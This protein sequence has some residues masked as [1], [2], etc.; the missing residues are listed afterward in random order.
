MDETGELAELRKKIYVIDDKILEL[1]ADRVRTALAVGKLKRVIGREVYD[2]ERER[3]I[4][5]RLGESAPDP[6]TADMVR[7]IFER[8]IDE[9][10]GAEQRAHSG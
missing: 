5:R 4:L 1:V 3:A 8:L 2:P 7:R 9:S 6:L 10:R